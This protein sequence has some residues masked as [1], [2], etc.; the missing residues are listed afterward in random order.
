MKFKVGDRVR[1]IKEGG[2]N[3]GCIGTIVGIKESSEFPYTIRGDSNF[4]DVNGFLREEFID[5][6]TDIEMEENLELISQEKIIN[7]TNKIMSN[8]IEF[9]KNALLTDNEKLLR[10]QGLKDNCGEYTQ[11]AKE[12]VLLK[13]VKDNE[14]YLI[15]T[16]TAK[17]AEEKK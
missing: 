5:G 11:D 4:P 7:K 9:A 16:A 17:E 15:D 12:L 1:I 8:I 2:D 3:F 10:K 13:L 6:R 14:Q